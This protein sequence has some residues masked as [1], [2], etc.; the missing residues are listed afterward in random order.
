MWYCI[1]GPS[2][3]G[4]SSVTR[5]LGLHEV[6]ST[7][8]RN[9]REGEINDVHYHF[10]SLEEFKTLDLAEQAEYSGNLY[11]FQRK[12]LEDADD[13]KPH[14]MVME[15]QGIRAI[16][17]LYPGMLKVIYITAT[18][19]RLVENMRKRGDTNEQIVDRLITIIDTKELSNAPKADVVISGKNV[20]ELVNIANQFIQDMES[21]LCR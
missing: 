5:G 8:T 16:K 12:D 13:G 4:K 6:V 18:A 20:N 3:V 19:K 10:V 15:I 14:L 9:P 2:G 21:S 7:T 11:G 17:K 1:L